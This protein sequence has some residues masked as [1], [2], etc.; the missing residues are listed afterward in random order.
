MT[1]E[2]GITDGEFKELP[3]EPGEKERKVM[4]TLP[5][6]QAPM[7]AIFTIPEMK[8]KR[9]ELSEFYDSVMVQNV[10]FGLIPGT[11]KPSLYKSGAEMLCFRFGLSP[12]IQ[13]MDKI[14]DVN[15]GFVSYEILCQ[16]FN[17]DGL[18]VGEGVGSCN[19]H[20][21]KYR[22]RWLSK[23]SLIS[24]GLVH[25]DIAKDQH[26]TGYDVKW[27]GRFPKYKVENKNIINLANTILKMATKRAFVD[28]VLRVTGAGRIF[29][30][31]LEDLD[32]VGTDTQKPRSAV[33]RP[34]ST[35]EKK[36]KSP[37]AGE[38]MQKDTET[39]TARR[40]STTERSRKLAERPAASSKPLHPE[41]AKVQLSD[42]MENLAEKCG[43][44]GDVW[45]MVYHAKQKRS[46]ICHPMP[47]G[48]CYF[49]KQI[50]VAADR[51]LA[52]LGFADIRVA[53]PF[54]KERFGMT[55]SAMRAREKLAV[56]S[57]VD[58]GTLVVEEK[59]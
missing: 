12:R 26:P 19:N 6:P 3:T 43:E 36:D 51:A 52:A 45:Q 39:A 2:N 35:S 40:Q 24:A 59:K 5:I 8:G 50:K 18:L 27:F 44:H 11:P 49:D 30:Q 34:S 28:A 13:I 37:D 1:T 17:R 23:S 9:D 54:F 4:P 57:L 41:L 7:T 29:T 56:I 14:F 32:G 22:F 25:P 20:E 55:W 15:T 10:D 38:T 53:A 33:R 21:D 42:I 47:D 58:S 31:D 48:V 46:F 16:L